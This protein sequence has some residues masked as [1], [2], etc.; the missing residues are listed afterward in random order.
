LADYSDG[1]T[2][3]PWYKSVMIAG[4]ID[5]ATVENLKARM[6]YSDDANPD[7]YWINIMVEVAL[8]QNL[9]RKQL[10]TVLQALNRGAVI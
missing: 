4:V 9:Q 10:P 2:G 3:S 7:P 1:S 5:K 8:L 6:G